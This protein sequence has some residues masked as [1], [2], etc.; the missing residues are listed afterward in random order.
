MNDLSAFDGDGERGRQICDLRVTGKTEA[1]ICAML[2]VTVPDIHRALFYSLECQEPFALDTLAGA[3][4][5]RCSTA[6]RRSQT[7]AM[8]QA[9][10]GEAGVT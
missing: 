8:S 5:D 9:R 10:I 2:G 4:Q 1:E 7:S 3:C 6:A